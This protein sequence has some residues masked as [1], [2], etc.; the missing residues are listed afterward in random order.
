MSRKRK[1]HSSRRQHRSLLARLRRNSARGESVRPVRAFTVTVLFMVAWV[2]IRYEAITPLEEAD[3]VVYTNK[4]CK[5]HLPWIRQLRDAGLAVGVVQ[6]RSIMNTQ[7]D[8]GVP[9]EFAACHTAAAE[10]YW[11]E[12][13]VPAA[14]IAKLLTDRPE[15]IGGLAHLRTEERADGRFQWEVVTYDNEGRLFSSE[16]QAHSIDGTD[17]LAPHD[18]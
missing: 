9:R 5:C 8:I 6:T 3:I 11:I 1:R 15:N 13:H 7:A 14:S 16:S 18:L 12:G 4:S 2:I 17:T 10:G